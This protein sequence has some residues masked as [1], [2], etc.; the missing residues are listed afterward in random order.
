M[1]LAVLLD[2]SQAPII[3]LTLRM[4]AQPQSHS[5]TPM[6]TYIPQFAPEFVLMVLE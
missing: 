5:E 4:V 1:Y 2:G 3:G 6:N